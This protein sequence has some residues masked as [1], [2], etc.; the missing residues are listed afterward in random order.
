MDPCAPDAETGKNGS[1][2]SHRAFQSAMWFGQ[3]CQ[4][5]KN[6]SAEFHSDALGRDYKRSSVLNEHSA[7]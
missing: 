4:T 1:G 5:Q 2:L 7:Y 6:E 3:S